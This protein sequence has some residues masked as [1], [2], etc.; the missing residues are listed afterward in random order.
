MLGERVRLDVQVDAE[1]PEVWF[2]PE[3]FEQILLAFALFARERVRGSGSL[4]LMTRAAVGGGTV[5]NGRPPLPSRYVD[6]RVS[7]AGCDPI[8]DEDRV[9]LFEPFFTNESIEG[10][11]GVSLGGVQ[12]TLGASGGGMTLERG[13]AGATFSVR[14][15]CS[16]LPTPEAA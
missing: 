2:D 8:G 7:V 4:T 12:A 9:R 13:G 15:P 16:E 11:R 14:L 1:T 6:L 3:A 5:G 10:S